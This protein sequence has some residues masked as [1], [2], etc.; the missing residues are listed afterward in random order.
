MRTAEL[1]FPDK[2][3]RTGFPLDPRMDPTLDTLSGAKVSVLYVADDRLP[4]GV[5][6]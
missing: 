1:V 3:L 2:E 4:G 6:R 5:A